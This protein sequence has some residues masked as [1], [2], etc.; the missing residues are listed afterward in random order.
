MSGEPLDCGSGIFRLCSCGGEAHLVLNPSAGRGRAGRATRVRLAVPGGARDAAVWHVTQGPGHAGRIVGGLP[1]EALVVAVGGDGTV[2]EVAAACVGT[3]RIMGVLPAGSG[4]DYVKALG[5]GTNLRRALEVLVGGKV[6]VVDAAEV[7]GVPFNNG[8]G[9]GFDAEVAA[10]VAEA[11]AYLGGTGGT[12]GPSGGC[13]RASGATRPRS[14]STAGRRRGQDHTRRGGPRHHLRLDVPA[15]AGGRAGRRSLRCH[16]VRG[17]QPGR[18][19]AA[20][21]GGARGHARQGTGRCT[22]P[23]RGR[24]RWSSRRRSRPTSTVRCSRRPATSG[25]GCCPERCASWHRNGHLRGGPRHRWP[26]SARAE[27]MRLARR[28]SASEAPALP[29]T[30]QAYP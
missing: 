26:S 24:S 9:I 17:G 30:K 4:N 1:E 23:A 27:I 15:R 8:L 10:G 14:G 22:W 2:H 16:L 19:P 21:T 28:P 29:G 5:V 20:H 11:P 3:G 25:R 18:G 12:C 6:R 7:N 13:S